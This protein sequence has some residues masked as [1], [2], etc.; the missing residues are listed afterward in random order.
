[1]ITINDFDLDKINIMAVT[2]ID[3]TKP[4]ELKPDMFIFDKDKISGDNMWICTNARYSEEVLMTK[5][6]RECLQIFYE[7]D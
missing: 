7:R 3:V 6:H 4:V 2:N 1:M 5:T